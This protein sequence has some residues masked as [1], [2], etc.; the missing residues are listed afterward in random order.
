MSNHAILLVLLSALLHASWNV[1]SK[2]SGDP[3][4]FLL[5]ALAFSTLLYAP[6]FLWMQTCVH[7]PPTVVFCVLGSGVCAGFYFM[8]LGKA[9]LCGQISVAYPVARSFPILLVTLG[10]LILN[11]RPSLHGTAGVVLVV[12]GCFVLPWER[13]TRGPEGFCLANY[14]NASIAWALGAAIFTASYSIIDKIA[15]AAMSSIPTSGA[16]DKVNYVYLQ[17]LISWIVVA[18]CIRLTGYKIG[19]ADRGR[20]IFAG[21]LFLVS[22][23]LILL[24]LTTDPVAYVVSFRQFSIVLTTL[25]SMLWIERRLVWPRLVGAGMIFAGIVLIGFA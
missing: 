15:A 13:F 8:C 18:C 11:E 7:Y 23:T 20:A 24:A 12:A 1:L 21:A 6:L 5:R 19:A 10:G 17:N 3:L 2:T 9:Y 4:T 25:A 14:R 16:L 22:Y